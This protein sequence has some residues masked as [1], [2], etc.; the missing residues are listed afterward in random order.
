MVQ[1]YKYNIFY[2]D[3]VDKSKIPVY[4]IEKDGDSDG[5]CI[6]KFHAGLPYE[7]VAFR[8]V[9]REWEYSHKKGYMC[10]FQHGTL[11]LYFNFKRY[12]YRH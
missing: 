11:Q 8:I 1:G 4:T 9:N 3:L 5:T 2:P 10:A 7:D 12:R 6:I